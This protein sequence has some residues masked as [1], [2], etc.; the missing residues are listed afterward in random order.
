MK[1]APEM[2][3][4]TPPAMSYA[5]PPEMS[6]AAKP[7]VSHAAK[8]EVSYAASPDLSMYLSPPTQ[9]EVKSGGFV[10]NAVDRSGQL[11]PEC[12]INIYG[13]LIWFIKNQKPLHTYLCRWLFNF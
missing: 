7:E 5:T 4:A 1:P 8:P 12:F 6:Y 10:P 11:L 9:P 13:H 2:S 3:Y